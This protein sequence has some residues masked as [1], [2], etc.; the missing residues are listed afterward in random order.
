[1]EKSVYCKDDIKDAI[2]SMCMFLKEDIPRYTSSP[3]T[4]NV[5]YMNVQS[6][7]RHVADV[8]RC[9][10]H[11]QPNCIAVTETWHSAD[12]SLDMVQID[13]YSFH[14]CPRSVSYSSSLPVLKELQG[15]QHGGVGMYCT[16]NVAYEIINVPHVNMECLV[17]SFVSY[18]I[19]LVIIYRPPSYPISL[20]KQHLGKLL[21]W[22]DPLSEDI[23]VIGDFNDDIFKS[24][25]IAQFVIS[26]G[27]V[28]LVTQATTENG[29]LIDHVYVKTVEYGVEAVIVPTYFSDHEAIVCR[30]C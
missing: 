21:D 18:N 3:Q 26:R 10:Q 20:F 11:L 25:S 17:Y 19:V 13:G 8:A 1:M 24:S 15:Q 27:Y 6:L 9:T 14:S 23:A 2:D 29:T 28:Q 30:F 4:L 7:A 5:F 12:S 22:V 16:D